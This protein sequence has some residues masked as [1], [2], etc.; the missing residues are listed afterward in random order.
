MSWEGFSRDLGAKEA[1][2]GF[3]RPA[4]MALL[5]R[6]FEHLD[7]STDWDTLKDADDELLINSLSM[8]LEFSGRRQTGAPG[9]AIAQHPS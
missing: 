7:L 8:L 2:A 3:Q 5:K 1:D 4:F 6:Y 9:G